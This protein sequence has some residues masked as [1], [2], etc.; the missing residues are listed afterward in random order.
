VKREREVSELAPLRDVRK[1][2]LTQHRIH[3]RI[4]WSRALVRGGQRSRD[5]HRISSR[6]PELS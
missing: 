2:E 6:A 3:D 4:R 1:E 5:R